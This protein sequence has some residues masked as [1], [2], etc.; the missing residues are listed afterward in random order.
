MNFIKKKGFYVPVSIIIYFVLLFNL[1]KIIGALTIA[2]TV[3]LGAYLFKKNE[4]FKKKGIIS[5]VLT[6]IAL[7]VVFLFCGIGG[8]IYDPV[9]V[10]RHEL[11]TEKLKQEEQLKEVEELKEKQELALKEEADRKK[12]EEEK[13][14]AEEEV[15]KI[16][17]EEEKI[18]AEEDKKKQEEKSKIQAEEHKRQAVE[19]AK[20]EAEK[21]KATATSKQV[22]EQS[23]TYVWL[24][25]TGE[26][27][28]NISNCGKMNPN[29]ASK[30]TLEKAKSGGYGPC[31]KCG[32]PR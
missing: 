11:A 16:A 32:P 5:K 27:Y 28:H 12:I 20:V 8:L 19:Q 1:P 15:K 31:S 24:S 30:V 22:A 7:L 6:I 18:K 29:R 17:E 3:A 26:K 9:S 10:E 25:E 13:L 21:R 2:S 4:R 23:S 14:K